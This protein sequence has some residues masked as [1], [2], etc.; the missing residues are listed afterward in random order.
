M[1]WR[2]E[3]YAGGTLRGMLEMEGQKIDRSANGA[4]TIRN[5]KLLSH[6]NLVLP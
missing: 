2:G 6:R 3:V 1:G 5:F 4:N